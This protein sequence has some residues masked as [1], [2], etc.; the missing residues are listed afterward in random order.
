M[1]METIRKP[2]TDTVYSVDA[3]VTEEKYLDNHK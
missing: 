2:T 3:N 1:I